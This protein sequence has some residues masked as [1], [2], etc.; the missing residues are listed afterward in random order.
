MDLDLCGGCR[1]HV[2]ATETTCPF[3]GAARAPGS[4]ELPAPDLGRPAPR[5]RAQR[6]VLGA[7]VVASIGIAKASA[8]TGED[9]G[10]NSIVVASDPT[11]APAP[12]STD[13]DAGATPP[14][15]PQEEPWMDQRQGNPCATVGGCCNSTVVCPPY[16]CVFP[17]EACDILPV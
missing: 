5:A 8:S 3:C 15:L 7:A 17:D 12:A 10:S 9:A 16:G 2:R 13:E 6:Y 11:S 14:S 1:R 4:P